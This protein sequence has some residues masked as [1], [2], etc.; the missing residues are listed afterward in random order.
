[1]SVGANWTHRPIHESRASETEGTVRV[2]DPVGFTNAFGKLEQAIEELVG[3]GDVKERLEAATMKLSPIFPQDFPA[4]HLRDEY[5]DIRQAL[6]W[7]PSE[8]GSGQGLAESN[9]EAMREEEAGM[10]AKSLFSLYTSAAEAL[11]GG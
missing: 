3:A 5:A 9:L 6:T 10:L 7:L 2:A 11:Y 1:M 8:E 4:G